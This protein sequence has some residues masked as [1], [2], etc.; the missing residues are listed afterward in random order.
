MLGNSSAV[1]AMPLTAEI[2]LPCRA[3][4]ISLIFAPNYRRAIKV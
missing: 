2:L 3:A 1:N 4:L